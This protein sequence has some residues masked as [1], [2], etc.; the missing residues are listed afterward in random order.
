[1]PKVLFIQDVEKVRAELADYF[2]SNEDARYVRRLDMLLLLCDHHSI[3][4][5]AGLF[6]VDPT[7]LQRLV[8]R[9]NRA[10]RDGLRDQPGRGRRARLDQASRQRLQAELKEPPGAYGYDQT[11][12]SGKL[13]A[14]HLQTHYGVQLKVRRCQT[15]FHQLGF[16]LQ[17]PRKT[18]A[19]GDPEQRTAFKKNS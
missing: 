6:K 18:P 8:H 5:V 16:S 11:T 13:L 10:G 3:P 19:G 7:T 14:H 4:S 12:W 17:R 2:A 1:M 15:L 9:F